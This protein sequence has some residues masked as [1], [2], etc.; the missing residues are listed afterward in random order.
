MRSKTTK[1]VQGA[2]FV[3][4]L[5]AACRP[6]W[7][8]IA[9]DSGNSFDP[10]E[11]ELSQLSEMVQPSGSLSEYLD[12]L[13]SRSNL[14]RYES[15]LPEAA[16]SSLLLLLPHAVPNS[17]QLVAGEMARRGRIVSAAFATGTTLLT[18]L[19]AWLLFQRLNAATFAI[20]LLGGAVLQIRSAHYFLPEAPLTFAT[21]LGLLG[22]TLLGRGFA[23]AGAT[24]GG[25]G[26]A[27]GCAIDPHGVLL[28]PT[29]LLGWL[30]SARANRLPNGGVTDRALI[31]LGVMVLIG[32]IGF[33]LLTPYTFAEIGGIRLDSQFV[34]SL[35]AVLGISRW[36]SDWLSLEQRMLQTD[37]GSVL[38]WG[39]GIPLSLAM[40][41]GIAGGTVAQKIPPPVGL[42]MATCT[43]YAL[44]QQNSQ[45]LLFTA[46]LPALCVFGGAGLAEVVA[47]ER[48]LA[49]RALAL[50]LLVWA[51]AA[52]RPYSALFG[53]DSTLL[54]ASEWIEA[55]V[56]PSSSISTEQGDIRLPAAIGGRVPGPY[57]YL[58]LRLFG[59]NPALGQRELEATWGRSDF[60]ISSS[61]Y[62]ELLMKRISPRATGEW[63]RAAVARDFFRRLHNS[64]LGMEVVARFAP[65][66]STAA[67][68]LRGSWVPLSEAPAWLLRC[69]APEVTIHRRVRETPTNRRGA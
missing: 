30:V 68:L 39:I 46:L 58:E 25:L 10:R 8:G 29:L 56:P 50:I 17:E 24:C 61:Q 12:P 67:R 26:L 54:Q 27:L 44:L 34:R 64:E 31:A 69:L 66:E 16:Y 49:A 51:T 7:S 6:L 48:S 65:R 2:L 21:T 9:W 36:D 42:W 5:I 37:I 53:R 13:R 62:P 22:A 55:N 23:F 63:R 11:R 4:G 33:R 40:I 1:F 19:I 15:E 47:R 20:L 59:D 45:L 60:H 43:F 52:G 41:A 14:R 32:V 3:L 57:H 38:S 35:L 28:A 18:G